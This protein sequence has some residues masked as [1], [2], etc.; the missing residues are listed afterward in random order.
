MSQHE[1]KLLRKPSAKLV[2]GF[3]HLETE[4]SL[5]D[6]TAASQALDVVRR[7][8]RPKIWTFVTRIFV[9][10]LILFYFTAIFASSLLIAGVVFKLSPSSF[11]T[12][13]FGHYFVLLF[14]AAMLSLYLLLPILY[15]YHNRSIL[16]P[17]SKVTLPRVQIIGKH[18]I[19]NELPNARSEWHWTA[20]SEF[21][22]TKSYFFITHAVGYFVAVP[23]SAFL[24][25]ADAGSFAELCRNALAAARSQ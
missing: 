15:R 2:D 1:S 10:W 23:R 11:D 25:E 9:I 13:L 18:T 3:W 24:N 16:P 5:S 7:L 4:S 22:E 14:C 6:T 8:N 21:I 19:I 17:G 12:A 20:V